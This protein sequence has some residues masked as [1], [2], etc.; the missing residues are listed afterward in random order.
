MTLI[1]LLLTAVVTGQVAAGQEQRAEE[2]EA[3]AREA[4][5]LSEVALLMTEPNLDPALGRV[6]E[7]LRGELGCWRCA[8]WSMARQAACW[9][10]HRREPAPTWRR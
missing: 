6:A 3:N 8:S 2:A 9:P 10:A 1:L 7:R 5:L 4:R